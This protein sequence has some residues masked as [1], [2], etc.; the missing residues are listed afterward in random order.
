MGESETMIVLSLLDLSS[1]VVTGILYSQLL[2]V[3]LIVE[4]HK[5]VDFMSRVG[6]EDLGHFASVPILLHRLRLSLLQ[7]FS[8]LLFIQSFLFKLFSQLLY[9][10]PKSKNLSFNLL[11]LEFSRKPR[12]CWTH[13]MSIPG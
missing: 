12:P 7:S 8:Y 2:Q 13:Q 1:V 3:G 5:V 9:L 6:I 4:N 10:L 11:F